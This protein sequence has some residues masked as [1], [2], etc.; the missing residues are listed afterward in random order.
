MSDPA[1][2]AMIWRA[3]TRSN[4]TSLPSAVSTAWSSTRHRA[5]HAVPHGGRGEQ[6]GQAGRVGRAPAVAEGEQA[7]ARSEAFA[8]GAGGGAHL[9]CRRSQ[10]LGAK[11]G[12]R[13]RLG[14]RGGGEVVEERRGIAA[15]V[16]GEE[17]VQEVG[18]F[19]HRWIP[20]LPSTARS[21]PRRGRAGGR[22]AR[23]RRRATR[24]SSRRRG[25]CAPTTSPSS[26]T[27]CHLRRSALVAARD[28]RRVGRARLGRGAEQTRVLEAHVGQLPQHVVPQHQ[29]AVVGRGAGG[30]VVDPDA[31]GRRG[32]R[33]GGGQCRSTRRRAPRPATGGRPQPRSATSPSATTTSDITRPRRGAQ[34]G[35]RG[36]APA[37][38]TAGSARLPTITG[39]T[40]STAT[41][42]PWSGQSGARHHRVA[43]PRTGERA[44]TPHG[45]GPHRR[46]DRCRRRCRCSRRRSPSATRPFR[47]GPCRR[48]YVLSERASLATTVGR[49]GDGHGGDTTPR[50][51]R[52]ERF[53]GVRRRRSAAGVPRGRRRRRRTMRSSAS[54]A[55]ASSPRGTG[56]RS[57]SSD[58]PTPTSSV[59]RSRCCSRPP[60][61]R[62]SSGSST[63]SLP[64]ITSTGSRPT[65]SA[66]AACTPR[67]RCH[68]P[69]SPDRAGRWP[70]PPP[71]PVTSPSNASPRR[72]WRRPK[73]ACA[74]ARALAHVGRWLWDIGSGT[75]QWSD[76]LHRIH[77]VDPVDFGG[78]LEAH[79][80]AVTPA[81]RERVLDALQRAVELGRPFEQEYDIVTTDDE[82]RHLYAR[83]EP[84]DRRQRVRRRAPGDRAG[85]LR[86]AAGQLAQPGEV[87][88]PL[89]QVG[90]STAAHRSRRR[91]SGRR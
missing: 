79:V 6:V 61:G 37:M 44:P 25:P 85:R 69:R 18:A 4:P 5:G 49:G 47:S 89:D 43:P 60:C 23:R 7:A 62:P 42:R 34:R 48:L 45:R 12:A 27:R 86:P 28:A 21:P 74:R 88:D 19:T 76:E 84:T 56:A 50:V 38:L 13:G 53:D 70:A 35:D 24:R 54:T 8:H 87:A 65:S 77:D 9:C 63:S 72:P 29:P 31:D 90:G 41:C 2:W 81:D 16:V 73:P 91:S 10:G 14:D 71:S 80:A 57:A 1:P 51:D 75:V 46:S 66:R 40:N 52:A 39:C 36:S 20:T 22:R 58:G 17:R 15:V 55:T 59:S 67:S 82:P 3:N 78:D 83:A 30:V 64:V 26:S 33:P 32:G 11:G 68:S